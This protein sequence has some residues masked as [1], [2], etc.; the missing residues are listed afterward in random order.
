MSDGPSDARREME[1]GGLTI[2]GRASG[3]GPEPG[4]AL[5]D[6]RIENGGRHALLLGFRSYGI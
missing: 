1:Q 6:T 5:T 4:Y 2:V 3:S